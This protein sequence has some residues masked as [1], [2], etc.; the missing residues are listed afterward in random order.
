MEMPLPACRS[1]GGDVSNPSCGGRTGSF[2]LAFGLAQRH[3]LELVLHCVVYT[4]RTRI[5]SLAALLI[6]V[7]RQVAVSAADVET[8]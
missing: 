6:G 1:P 3:R 5:I 7:A 4:L 2:D 8:D